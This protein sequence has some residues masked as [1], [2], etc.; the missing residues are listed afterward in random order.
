MEQDRGEL[1]GQDSSRKTWDCLLPDPDTW[2]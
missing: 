2:Q 1:V